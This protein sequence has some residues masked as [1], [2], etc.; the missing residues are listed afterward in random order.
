M[1]LPVIDLVCLWGA[2]RMDDILGLAQ[3]SKR[4]RIIPRFPHR[5]LTEVQNCRW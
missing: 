5:Q 1:R 3:S 2:K 4:Q